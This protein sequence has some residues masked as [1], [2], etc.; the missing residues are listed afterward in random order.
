MSEQNLYPYVLRV[1]FGL[2]PAVFILL[3]FV[4]APYG[5]YARK[6][7]GP[8]MSARWAWFLME[9]PSWVTLTVCLLIRQRPAGAAALVLC[10][11]WV[12]HYLYRS[13]V[14]PLNLSRTA[15]PWPVLVVL[16]GGCFNLVN[17]YLNGRWLFA[18]GDMRATV[19]LTDPRFLA[20]IAVFFCGVG[21][22]VCSDRVLR[23]EKRDAA[24][25]Y[26]IPARGLHRLVAA[27]NYLGEIL[28]WGGWALACWSLPGLSFVV[29]SMANLAPRAASHRAWYRRKFAEYPR[30]R[31]RLVPWVW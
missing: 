21:I 29:W 24:G 20:G 14:Y 17:A 19:W 4:T 15:H 18:F 27:P 3:F 22:N 26:V 31:R 12:G 1:W 2:A 10:A 23:A 6:G 28:E 5:R 25:G 8:M 11:L 30:S 9:T 16:M 7:W 13:V